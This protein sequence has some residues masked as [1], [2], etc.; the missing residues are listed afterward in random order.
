M[1]KNNLDVK[2]IILLTEREFSKDSVPK[3]GGTFRLNNIVIALPAILGIITSIS[4]LRNDSTS[5][6]SFTYDT[7]NN[8]CKS[9][10]NEIS[11]L[12]IHLSTLL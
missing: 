11:E 9:C 2:E 1:K 8:F 12:T 6:S 4:L 5:L 7:L 10:I 3:Q